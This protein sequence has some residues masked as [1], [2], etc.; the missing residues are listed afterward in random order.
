MD[1]WFVKIKTNNCRFAL[2]LLVQIGAEIVA[3]PHSL[4]ALLPGDVSQDGRAGILRFANFAKVSCAPIH[5]GNG[6]VAA[7]IGPVC[8][9]S[10]YFSPN[11]PF[12]QFERFLGSLRKAVVGLGNGPI[13]LLRTS[14]RNQPCGAR[15]PPTLE[16]APSEGGPRKFSWS[17]WTPALLRLQNQSFGPSFQCWKNG[18]I[19]DTIPELSHDADSHRSWMLRSIPQ[20]DSKVKRQAADFTMRHQTTTSI[21]W[22]NVW[23][24]INKEKSCQKT[25]KKTHYHW[26]T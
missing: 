15:V 18:L 20:P 25:F 1:L 12:C 17:C 3:E 16:E 14:M 13:I 23:S 9:V 21:Q 2:D 7:R 10:A 8:V 6:F 26:T 19:G 22:Q 11:R 4:E 24:G 5:S